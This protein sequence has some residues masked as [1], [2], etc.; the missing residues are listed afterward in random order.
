MRWQKAAQGFLLVASLLVAIPACAWL[1]WPLW[2]EAVLRRVLATQ[3]IELIAIEWNRPAWRQ[4]FIRHLVLRK[5]SVAFTLTAAHTA[6]TYDIAALR[7]SRVHDIDIA[8]LQLDLAQFNLEATPKQEDA[9]P[10]EANSGLPLPADVLTQI[11]ARSVRIQQMQITTPWPDIAHWRGSLALRD[12]KLGVLLDNTD[13]SQLSLR[14]SAD[15]T[16]QI[17]LNLRREQ[18]D[19]LHVRN[20]FSPAPDQADS[21]LIDGQVRADIAELA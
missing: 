15:I 14:L 9:T 5:S 16:N 13:A 1:T 7:Q 12:D 17:D 21:L 10:A 11:P 19:I 6:L 20:Q 3:D 8:Q 18:I 4:L 2:S